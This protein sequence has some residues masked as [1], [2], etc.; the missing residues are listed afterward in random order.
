MLN[1][2][3]MPNGIPLAHT[4][5]ILGLGLGLLVHYNVAEYYNVTIW[6]AFQWPVAA[7]NWH[8]EYII[9]HLASRTRRN[10][11]NTGA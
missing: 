3:D 6:L 5:M 7:G 9:T 1:R 11:F 2:F 10:H 4:H 8:S